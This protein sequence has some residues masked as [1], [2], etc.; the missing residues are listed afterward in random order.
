MDIMLK[1]EYL[2]GWFG[3]LKAS[4][5]ATVN[6]NE[7][8]YGKDKALFN[9]NAMVSY[10]SPED[11]VVFLGSAKNAAEPGSW[12]ETDD[13]AFGIPGSEMDALATK[14]G[15]QT[16]GQA[17]IN[18]N[19]A[20]LK[21]LETTTS[22]SYNFLQKDAFNGIDGSANNYFS[23]YSR[24]DDFIIRQRLLAQYKKGDAS[25]HSIQ[26]RL[27]QHRPRV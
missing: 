25:I 5:G 26:T 27:V 24:N 14:Q 9:S 17:G 22:L 13:F 16:T 1:D 6:R 19:T 3:N 4:G 15:L 12:S 18:Y 11:Q 23:S 10:Y 21:G 20:R 8:V 7:D 2:N